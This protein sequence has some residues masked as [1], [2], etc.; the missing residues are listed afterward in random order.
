LLGSLLGFVLDSK[1][2]RI[3][4]L[5]GR[6]TNTSVKTC[7]YLLAVQYEYMSDSVFTKII[8]GEIPSHKIYEDEFAFAFMD[9]HPIQP[10]MVLVVS[11]RPAEDFMQLTP[12]E[13]AGLMNAVQRVAQ[14]M[15]TVFPDKKR[16]GVM[17]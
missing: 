4:T 17:L 2:K 1:L 14:K 13:L 8:K 7:R 10:G 15:K 6:F 12:A 16:I 11:K 3:T 5:Q 9:I